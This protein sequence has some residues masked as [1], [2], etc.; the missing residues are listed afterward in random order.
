M[1]GMRKRPT[2]PHTFSRCDSI[3]E[4]GVLRCILETPGFQKMSP[5]IVFQEDF[6]RNPSTTCENLYAK[7][8]ARDPIFHD[9]GDGGIHAH[10]PRLNSPN[11]R[12]IQNETQLAT[13]CK[14]DAKMGDFFEG[15]LTNF[16]TRNRKVILVCCTGPIILVL[17]HCCLHFAR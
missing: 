16:A 17:G 9:T 13:F 12:E 10:F 3:K 14:V 8:S 5:S 4:P 6:C 2:Q 1:Q 7:T 15:L 11:D